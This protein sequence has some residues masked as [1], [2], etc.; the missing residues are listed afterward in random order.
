MIYSTEL[1]TAIWDYFIHNREQLKFSSITD[2]IG[3]FNAQEQVAGNYLALLDPGPRK[4][5]LKELSKPVNNNYFKQQIKAR[6]A[7][8]LFHDNGYYTIS[9]RD[10]E[11][12]NK[13]LAVL[14]S[15]QYSKLISGK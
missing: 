7:R 5:A 11:V 14:S 3:S 12:V 9:V 10:D 15:G 8:L 13:A 1:K 6:M 2:F 4:E